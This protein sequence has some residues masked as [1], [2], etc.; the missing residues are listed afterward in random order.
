MLQIIFISFHLTNNNYLFSFYKDPSSSFSNTR[1][2]AI[3]LKH[4]TMGT[5]LFQTIIEKDIL[6]TVIQD[7]NSM[8]PGLIGYGQQKSIIFFSKDCDPKHIPKLGDKVNLYKIIL[9]ILNYTSCVH[10]EF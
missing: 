4:L 6:G 5:V 3:R 9:I 1:Q 8:E 7:T 2:S 10:E